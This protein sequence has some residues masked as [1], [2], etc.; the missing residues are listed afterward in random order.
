[1]ARDPKA[2]PQTEDVSDL[3]ELTHKQLAFVQGILGGMS[4][5]DAYRAA[6]ACGGW[7]DNAVWVE[8]SNQKGNPK[9]V[10]WLDRIRQDMLADTKIT[11]ESHTREL[12]RLGKAAEKAGNYGASAKCVELTGRANGLYVDRIE[13]KDTTRQAADILKALDPAL[14]ALLGPQ[15]GLD[16]GETEETKH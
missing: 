7:T 15:L 2:K 12:L 14:L 6:Y 9:V 8:A 3:P 1:M 5:S 11:L 10:L 4:A 16:T 13:T